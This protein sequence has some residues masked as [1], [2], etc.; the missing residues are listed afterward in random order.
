MNK[1]EMLKE[2]EA[3]VLE[4][5]EAQGAVYDFLDEIDEA[6]AEGVEAVAE[7]EATVQAKKDALATITDLGELKL[8]QAEIK[9]LEE[10]VELLKVVTAN[11]ANAMLEELGDKADAFFKLHKSAKFLYQAVDNILVANTSLSE[12]A[13]TKATMNKYATQLNSAFAGVRHL[14]LDTKIVA[15]ADQNRNFKGTH[16]GQRDLTTELDVFESKVRSY[17]QVLKT[18]GVKF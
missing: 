17:M 10:D 13:E 18:S 14:L 3:K 6:K 2:L 8:A 11:K 5:R 4:V 12:L 16:L 7:A 1:V 15:Q 9:A